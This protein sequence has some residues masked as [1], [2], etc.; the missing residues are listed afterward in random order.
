M[1]LHIFLHPGKQH[2]G[3]VMDASELQIQRLVFLTLTS[4]WLVSVSAAQYQHSW[5]YQL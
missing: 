4:V 2:L 3:T 5:R 1:R